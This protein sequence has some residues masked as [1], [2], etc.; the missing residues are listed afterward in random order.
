MRCTSVLIFFPAVWSRWAWAWSGPD[1]QFQISWLTKADPV[2]ALMVSGVI[3]YV[4]S[5]LARRTVDA[6]LDAAPVGCA[7]A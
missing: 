1:S 6:L 7:A 2:A 3:V 5:R 4:S